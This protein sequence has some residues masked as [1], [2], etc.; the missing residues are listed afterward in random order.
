MATQER[1]WLTIAEV[2]EMSGLSELTVRRHIYRNILVARQPGGKANEKYRI[3]LDEFDR[4]YSHYAKP[5]Q[6]NGWKTILQIVEETG[7]SESTVRRNIYSGS[8]LAEQLVVGGT[9]RIEEKNFQKWMKRR[10]S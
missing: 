1:T 5:E 4:W 9:F 3:E 10:N 2:A 6:M 7:M 8:L